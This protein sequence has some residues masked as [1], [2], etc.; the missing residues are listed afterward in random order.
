MV[1]N[2]FLAEL[3]AGPLRL[4]QGAFST[5]LLSQAGF[6]V[7]ASPKLES[8]RPSFSPTI[9]LLQGLGYV[10]PLAGVSVFSSV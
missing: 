4:D 6:L 8:L 9:F 7:V 10:I 2:S 1:L 3:A 5:Q